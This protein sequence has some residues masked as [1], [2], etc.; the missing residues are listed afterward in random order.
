VRLAYV[1]DSEV[2]GGAEQYVAHLMQ[3][4]PQGFEPILVATPGAPDALVA[5]AA[6]REQEVATIPVVRGKFD[7]VR[8]WAVARVLRRLR[9]DLVHV[10]LTTAGNNR[11]VVGVVALL[12]TRGVAT[13]HSLAPVA[14]RLQRAILRRAYGRLDAVVAVAEEE[15][16]Q[17]C[18]E[19]GLPA[20]SVRLIWN[21]VET[22][23]PPAPRDRPGP[24]RVGAVS[25]MSHE[26]GFD[27]LL[28]ALALLT[29]EGVPVEVEL[30]GTGP[31]LARLRRLAEGLPATLP[32]FVDD[33]D[34]FL[35]GLDVFCLP[36]RWEGLPFALL[37]AMMAGLPCV[38]SDVGDIAAALGP[39]G[40][41]VP[42][43][44][45]GDLAAALRELVESPQRR[46]ELGTA[47]QERARERHSVEGMV[48]DTVALYE[49]LLSR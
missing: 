36:S 7:A 38:A 48:A 41:V 32:G 17:L 11:H 3:R 1:V 25:R 33:R 20:S 42:P 12:P 9:P 5:V 26:K 27:V 43:E 34:A 47:A 15:R 19:L 21:G 6:E 13:L 8:M 31:E 30:A 24:V 45:P 4:L 28:A 10:N 2:F 29:R 40:V 37:E 22:R 44:R 35:A 39:A 14:S 18:E 46:R 49:E 23:S 16:R